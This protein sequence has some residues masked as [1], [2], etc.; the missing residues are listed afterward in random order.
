LLNVLGAASAIAIAIALW[1]F[2]VFGDDPGRDPVGAVEGLE[3]P[4]I[5][6]ETEASSAP[7]SVQAGSAAVDSPSESTTPETTSSQPS[8]NTLTP[9]NTAEPEEE[10]Q[11]GATATECSASLTLTR[12]WDGGMEVSGTV[13]NTGS[14]AIESWE[15]DLGFSGA[16]IYHHWDM[17]HLDGDRYTN[18]DWN[19]RLEPDGIAKLGFLANTD[20]DFELPDSVPCTA[21]A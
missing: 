15:V 9:S 20:S 7:A 18:E 17:R 21:R 6:A 1:Q 13:V 5:A 10:S 4:S 8:E 16:E 3:P 11:E 2:G 12:A 14:E 19:G